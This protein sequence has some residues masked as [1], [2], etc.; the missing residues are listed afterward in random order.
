MPICA[1]KIC[2]M[3]TLLKYGKMRQH[4]KYVTIAYSR[5]TD[6]LKLSRF[7]P[8]QAVLRD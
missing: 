6:T 5:K 4:A 3:R 7:S 2:D 1:E 8:Q